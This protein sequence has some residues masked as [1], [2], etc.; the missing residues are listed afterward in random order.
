MRTTVCP[1]SCH[2]RSR[3]R[4][5]AKPRWT[6]GEVGSMPSFTRNGRPSASLRPSS[7]SG[8]TSTARRVGTNASTRASLVL[9][10]TDEPKALRTRVMTMVREHDDL[11]DEALILLAARSQQGALAVLYDRYGRRAYGLVL[12]VLRDESLAED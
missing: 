12:R 10:R 6:S 5:T 9:R 1:A 4:T 2:S 11:S 7:S 3:S 8:R